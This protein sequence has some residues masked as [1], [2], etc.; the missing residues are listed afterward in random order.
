MGWVKVVWLGRGGG[1]G[2]VV[3]WFGVWLVVINCCGVCG[4]CGVW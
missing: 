3:L 2:G 4:V 1:V